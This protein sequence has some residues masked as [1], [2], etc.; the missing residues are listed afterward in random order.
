MA[1]KAS[2]YLCSLIC[3]VDHC[4]DALR[5]ALMC[6]ADISPISFHVNTPVNVGVFPRLATTHTCRNFAKIQDWAHKNAAGEW[7]LHVTQEEAKEIIRESG[8]DHAPLEDIEFLWELFPGDPF[9]QHWRDHPLE[10]ENF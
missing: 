4:I 6:N 8:F 1:F 10:N 5:Q 3:V 2:K 7:D 9:F